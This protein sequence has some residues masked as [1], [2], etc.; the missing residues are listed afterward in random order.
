MGWLRPLRKWLEQ[1]LGGDEVVNLEYARGMASLKALKWE[2]I[3][4]MNCKQA[5]LSRMERARSR[6]IGDEV[7]EV[8]G[9]GSWRSSYAVVKFL[10]FFWTKTENQFKILC[11]LK[12]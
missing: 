3:Y 1:N 11:R 7:R 6:G 12:I 5:N 2:I 4:S 8:L 10:A 9:S